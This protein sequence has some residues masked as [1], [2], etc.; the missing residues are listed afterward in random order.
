[1][2]ESMDNFNLIYD[3]FEYYADIFYCFNSW[4]FVRS[5]VSTTIIRMH[6]K[7]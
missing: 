5:I 7:I 1:M 4:I 3:I 6:I 2:K